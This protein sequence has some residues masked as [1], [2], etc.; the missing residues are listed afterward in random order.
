MVVWPYTY[1]RVDPARAGL[2]IYARVYI[3]ESMRIHVYIYIYMKLVVEQQ[4]PLTYRSFVSQHAYGAAW[5]IVAN[6]DRPGAFFNFF[7]F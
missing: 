4:T 2:Y 3:Y 6:A 5:S 7:H 1:I